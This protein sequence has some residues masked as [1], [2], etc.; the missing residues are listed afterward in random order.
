MTGSEAFAAHWL[1][2]EAAKADPARDALLAVVDL[3]PDDQADE[4]LEVFHDKVLVATA[5]RLGKVLR[6]IA[7]HPTRQGQGLTALLVEAMRK[8]LL[9]QGSLS[10]QVYTQ[11]QTAHLFE[12]LGFRR[13]A[14]ADEAVLLET[15][16]E[17]LKDFVADLERLAD[18]GEHPRGCIVLNANPFTRGHRWLVEQAL[19][20]CGQL[21]LI[22]LDDPRTIFAPQVRRELVRQGCADLANVTVLG[23]GDYV[24]SAGT[25]PRYFLKQAD[26]VARTQAQLDLA[27]FI[28]HIAPALGVV[29][30]FAGEE[31]LDPLT[32]LYN[33]AMASL[34]PPA[35]IAFT[36]F[37]RLRDDT[38][39]ISASR[40]R[41]AFFTGRLDEIAHC[42]PQTTLT[43]LRGPEGLVLRDNWCK[44]HGS[45]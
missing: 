3:D 21:F 38:A 42:V 4:V 6:Q 31:P 34:L 37:P 16:R 44:E 8:R 18:A 43:Y 11:P 12:T 25:F 5:A 33:R 27:L 17:G 15:G 26:T 22:V 32:A 9:A 39:V 45:C 29:A 1:S 13:L 24:I 7:V 20:R 19:S 35:G 23:G 40:V 28:G 30:R 41:Q 2:P 14:A 36:E 10:C